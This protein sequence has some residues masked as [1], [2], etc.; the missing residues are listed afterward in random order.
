MATAEMSENYLNPLR[1]KEPNRYRNKTI[2]L[3]VTENEKE[4][5]L[6]GMKSAGYGTLNNYILKMVLTGRIIHV[7]IQELKQA[8][9]PT[10]NYAHELNKIG[11]NINQVAKQM[12][13]AGLDKDHVSYFVDEFVKMKKNYEQAQENLLKEVSKL[14]NVK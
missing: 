7:D 4:K 13:Q 2:K 6:Q 3:R 8:L 1:K 11:N 12:N 10:G 5:I 9:E 14:T